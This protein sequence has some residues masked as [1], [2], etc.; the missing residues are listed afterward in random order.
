MVHRGD[1]GVIDEHIQPALLLSDL[2]EHSFDR[3]LIGNVE[4]AVP[5]VRE[6]TFKWGPA[7]ADDVAASTSIMLDQGAA[8]ALSRARNQDHLIIGHSGRLV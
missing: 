1:A 2:R 4:A 7:A 5:V 3:R 8:D 6:L